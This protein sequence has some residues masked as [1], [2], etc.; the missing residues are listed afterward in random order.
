LRK[1]SQRS[2]GNPRP[3]SDLSGEK[4]LRR[5]EFIQMTGQQAVKQEL[6]I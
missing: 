2:S 1:V 4:K 3:K 5:K 6:G